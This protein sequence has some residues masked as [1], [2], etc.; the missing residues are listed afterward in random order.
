[1][2]TVR[3]WT[4]EQQNAISARGGGLLVSAAAGSGKTAVLVERVI[5]LVCDETAPCPLDRLLVVTFTKAAASEMRERIGKALEA[6]LAKKPNSTYLLRQQMLLSSAQICTMDSFCSTLV[7]TYFHEADI[8]PDFRILD[9]SERR[10][11]EEETAQA[12]LQT[13]Y[14]DNSPAFQMLSGLLMQGANDRRLTDAVLDLYRYAQAYPDPEIWLQSIPSFYDE[15]TLLAE[16]IWGKRIL[17]SAA[18]RVRDCVRLLKKALQLLE[19]E[20]PLF[21]AY[22]PALQSDLLFAQ[23][24]LDAVCTPDW[25]AAKRLTESYSA[26]AFRRAPKGYTGNRTK[27]IVAALRKKVKNNFGKLQDL[28]PATETEHRED[29]RTLRPMVQVL[30]DTV[31]DFSARL[32]EAKRSENAYDFSDISHAALRLLVQRDTDGVVSRTPL[33]E[34]LRTQYKEILLDEYQDTNEA[35]ELLFTA[36]SD[37]ERNLFCVGDVKQSIYGFRLAMPEIFLRRRA[38]SADYDGIH[39]PARITLGN[40]FRS[41]KTVANGINYLF[42]QL[43]T[44][45]TCGVEYGETERLYASAAY[46]SAEDAPVELHL[47]PESAGRADRISPEAAHIAQCIQTM[48]ADKTPVSNENGGTRPVRYGDICILMRSLT[49]GEQYFDALEEAGIPAFYQKKGGFFAMRE[50]RTMVSLLKALNNPYDDVPLCACLFSPIWGFTPDELAEIKML[51]HDEPLFCKLSRADLDKCRRFLAD[52]RELHALST[53]LTPAALLRSIYETTGFQAIVGAMPGGENRKLNLQLLLRYAESYAEIGNN[54]L[55]GFLRYLNRLQDNEANVEAAT[56]VSEYADVVRI[57]TIHKSKGLEF[58]VVFL[59]KCG[60]AFNASDQRKPLLI[61]PKMK[62]GLKI[63]DPNRRRSFPSVPYVAAK[64]GIQADAQAE[65]LRVLYV[66]LTRAKERLIL[67]GSGNGQTGTTRIAQK[68]AEDVLGETSVSTAYVQSMNNYLSWI[69]AAY[70]KHPD[71]QALRILA[72]YTGEKEAKTEFR[73]RVVV[74]QETAQKEPSVETV[75]I[76]AKADPMLMQTIKERIEYIYPFLPLHACPAKISASALNARDDVFS[77]FAEARPAF[78]GKGG[79]T[80]AMRGTATH[81]FAQYCDFAAAKQDL[82]AE[83]R[84][85]CQIGKLTQEACEVLDRAALTAFLHSPLLTRMEKADFVCREQKF[86]VFL[87]AKEAIEKDDPAFENEQVL[88][89]GVIDCA[90]GENGDIVLVDYKTDRVRVP[91][92]LAARYKTQLSVYAYAAKQ[93]FEA[94]VREAYL[95]SFTLGQA[96]RVNI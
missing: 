45:E 88:L 6:E 35:Q 76:Y 28:F 37:N 95:Y 63:Y 93:I 21:E 77:F 24:L 84:R 38:A 8:S 41:R 13:L 19:T 85:L 27:E 9:D 53:V 2:S 46:D 61:H 75:P 81:T 58:P 34:S 79:M 43:M 57:M 55:S 89:Q 48:I 74:P 90:F 68:A 14:E 83:I 30:I 73:L 11:M 67:V 56:G 65:E 23:K 32:L 44:E 78:L 25:D 70:M 66:A 42:E 96:I 1:M 39:F 33:A 60:A 52:Y 29:M 47:L 7:K 26:D 87:P 82:E 71:A 72:D 91:E 36:L 51:S 20:P 18:V 3:T 15:E 12:C 62:L 40:N 22:A 10:A 49:G 50:I 59:A 92:E 69:C 94:E 31:L 4:P 64:L 80:P 16:S 54:S 17:E 5:R 86:T